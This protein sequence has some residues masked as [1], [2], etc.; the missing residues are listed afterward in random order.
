MKSKQ[1]IG[2]GAR[3]KGKAGENELA[4]LIRENW[5]YDV[6]RGH[7]FDHES[8][9]V[10]LQGIHCEVKRV[11][12]LNIYD[13]MS[14]AIVEAEIR[15]DGLPVVFWRKNHGKWKATMRHGDLIEISGFYQ[16]EIDRLPYMVTMSLPAFMDIYGEW[17]SHE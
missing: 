6:R 14:Q 12:R 11:E 15:N 4:R 1:D 8:D 13:A 9:M 5:G 2:R 10:G 16:D 3:N 7:V 17:I